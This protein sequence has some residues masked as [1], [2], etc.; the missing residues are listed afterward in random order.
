M[1]GQVSFGTFHSV[2]FRILKLAY[3]YDASDII[4][5]DQK[6]RLIREADGEGAAGAGG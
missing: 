5:E 4:R 2:F 3:Q 6:L 1:R